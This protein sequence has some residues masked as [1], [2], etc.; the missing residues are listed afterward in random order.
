MARNSL[1]CAD[2]PLRNYS[3]HSTA[4]AKHDGGGA[5]I[6]SYK[7]FKAPVRSSP[8]TNQ[9]PTLYRLDVLP[10]A[11]PTVSKH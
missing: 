9:H 1:L 8:A 11:Q 2:V 3:L 6:W 4:E 5:D 10:V 7:T